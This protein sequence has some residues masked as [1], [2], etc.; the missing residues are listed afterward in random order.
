MPSRYRSSTARAAAEK[1][2]LVKARE[3]P[4]RILV[5]TIEIAGMIP[6]FADGFRRLGHQVTTAISAS[7]PSILTSDTT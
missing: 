7:H 1:E 2:R 4:L 3:K 5:G 6:I